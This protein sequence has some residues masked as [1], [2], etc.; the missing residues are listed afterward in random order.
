MFGHTAE[1]PKN[2]LEFVMM[3]I[4]KV[5][6]LFLCFWFFV[7]FCSR[8]TRTPDCFYWLFIAEK[9]INKTF[10]G[11]QNVNASTPHLHSLYQSQYVCEP[12]VNCVCVW[13]SANNLV[14]EMEYPQ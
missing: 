4:V 9:N 5:F 12:R 11:K 7:L 6:S 3:E 13:D 1:L 2:D 8:D 10:D 14:S